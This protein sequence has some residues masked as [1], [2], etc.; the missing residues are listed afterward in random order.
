MRLR[1]FVVE[2]RLANAGLANDAHDLPA[3]GPGVLERLLELLDLRGA[4]D[5]SREPARRRRLEA[6]ADSGGT[7]KLVDLDWIGEPLHWRKTEGAD[8]D[9]AFG[10]RQRVGS[11]Q[12]TARVGQL[13]H[14]R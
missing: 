6:R 13:F 5:E 3:A 1:E 14:A 8:P 2:A 12:Y 9:V 11:E 7:H 4:P 10:Q